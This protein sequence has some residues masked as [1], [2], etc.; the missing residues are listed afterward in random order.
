M[1]WGARPGRGGGRGGA[2]RRLDGVLPTIKKKPD[3]KDPLDSCDFILAIK[4]VL[5]PSCMRRIADCDGDG[6]T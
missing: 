3:G 6:V 1:G 4:I 5:P 2:A